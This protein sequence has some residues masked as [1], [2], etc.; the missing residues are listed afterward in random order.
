MGFLRRLR[1]ASSPGNRDASMATVRFYADDHAETGDGLVWREISTSPNGTF[2]LLWRD[3]PD[4]DSTAGYR[5]SGL[6]RYRLIENGRGLRCDGRMERPGEGHVADNGTFILADSLFGEGLRS[7]LDIIDADGNGI[8]RREC[9]ANVLATWIEANGRYAAAHLA[10]NPDDE[11]D[12]ERFILFDLAGRSEAWSKPLETGRPDELEFD[13]P[14]VALW[15]T[16][17][18]FGRVGFGLTDGAVDTTRLCDIALGSGD[19]FMI[20]GLVEDEFGGGVAPDRRE[21]LVQA[22]DRA[23]ERLA[24]YPRHAARALRVAGEILEQTDP[25]RTLRYWDRA[26]AVD[27]KVGIGKRAAALRASRA[28][29]G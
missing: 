6:G 18:A 25:D 10:S 5:T 9:R 22:C 29:Q 14:G 12:D 7:R 4:D 23:A 24:P 13:V 15:L 19:G 1:G 21:A 26:I 16:N 17:K 27:P 11:R 28:R 20:L 3:A 2:A 8:I